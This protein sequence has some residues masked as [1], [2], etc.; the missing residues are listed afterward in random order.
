MRR[1]ARAPVALAR[2]A[3]IL[4]VAAAGFAACGG[5]DDDGDA[6]LEGVQGGT[7]DLGVRAPAAAPRHAEGAN[8]SQ[9]FAATSAVPSV[10]PE[11][12]KTAHIELEIGKNEL[13]RAV[14]AI[15][16]TA[17]RYGGFIHSTSVDDAE[18]GTGTVVLRIPSEEFDTALSDIKSEGEIKAETIS[19][20]DV[21]Q[22]FI[23]LEARL[24]NFEAQ[25]SVLLRLMDEATTISETIRV[26]NEL[27]GVQV[28]IEQLTGRLR[29]LEDRTSLGTI[30]VGI[31]ESGAPTPNAP[32]ALERAWEQALDVALSILSG[33]IVGLGALIPIGLLAGVALLVYR[34]LRPRPT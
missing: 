14:D 23:D 29:F 20:R 19:G 7:A 24:R 32:N 30:T 1:E 10:G 25:E 28:Q 8:E 15:E 33:L 13:E 26:Q 21:S 12:V 11:I 6:A 31:T 34:Q 17:A 4:L 18:A 5:H 22:E 16:A 27:S 9:A 3:A 2:V